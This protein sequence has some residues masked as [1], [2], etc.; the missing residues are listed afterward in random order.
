MTGRLTLAAWR[1][2]AG[3][4]Q[5][6]VARRLT[7]LLGRPV[8]PPSVCQWEAGVMPAADAAEAVREL[9][10]GRVTGRSFGR[11]PCP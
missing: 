1:Q 9:T 11:R 7:L 5:R 8:H 2:A 4:S 10:G 3:L 6:D